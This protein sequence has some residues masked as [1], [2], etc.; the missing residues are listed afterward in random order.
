MDINTLKT[1]VKQAAVVGSAV[2]V[3]GL[4]NAAVDT[5]E[6]TGELTDAA[7][8]GAAVA[9]VAILIPLGIKVF[10]YIRSAF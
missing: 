7:T 8:A 1:R 5:T 9:A 4:A 2:A 3:T 6:I 10:K